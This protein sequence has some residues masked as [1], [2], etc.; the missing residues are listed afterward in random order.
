MMM[1]TSKR[2]VLLGPPGTGKTTA[3][4]GI[5]ADLLASGYRSHEIAFVS[6]SRAAVAEAKDRVVAKTGIPAEEWPWMRTLHSA[7]SRS[8]GLSKDRFLTSSDMRD[9]AAR[10]AIGLDIG[11]RDESS[12]DAY[13]DADADPAKDS[14]LR[15]ALD[16]CR[17]TMAHPRDGI[18]R[19]RDPRREAE[20]YRVF[21]G[22]YEA[23]RSETAK[24]DHTDILEQALADRLVIP[25]RVL[26]VDEAQ[27]LSPLQQATLR[28]SIDKAERVWVAG[29]DDQA[30]YDFQGASPAWL[31][32]LTRSPSWTTRILDRSWRCP[33]EVR[34][35]AQSIAERLTERADKAYRARDGSGRY[36]TDVTREDA[37]A[38]V[39]T[40]TR[41]AFA[42]ARTRIGCSRFSSSLRAA[43]A[44]YIAERGGRSPLD[45]RGLRGVI[46]AL[47]AIYTGTPT[48]A[49]AIA[50]ALSS[51]VCPGERGKARVGVVGRGGKGRIEEWGRRNGDALVTLDRAEADDMGLDRA[52]TL[53]PWDLLAAVQ[54][55]PV[56]AGD[57]R[58]DLQWLRQLWDRNGRAW[59]EHC[60]IVTTWHG[61]KGREADI[62]VIDPALP[63]PAARALSRGGTEADT[64]HRC[65]YV[66]LT[67]ARREAVV[68]REDFEARGNYEF[69]SPAA[70]AERYPAPAPAWSLYASRRHE[71]DAT[72]DVL[73]ADIATP[74]GVT[75]LPAYA[76]AWAWHGWR[77]LFD[78][79]PLAGRD[80]AS[81]RRAVPTLPPLVASRLVE[82]MG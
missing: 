69:P 57:A 79:T 17:A 39:S 27:D 29:D 63:Y 4:M 15:S 40:G 60:C 19:L 65:A 76:L 33:E 34:A 52:Y 74:H 7:W 11:G 53:D 46:D 3:L 20:R 8:L 42:L 77:D 54:A 51:P 72:I 37:M 1:D 28:L 2:I 48:A 30:I 13:L 41:S 55:W 9:F 75:G 59:P 82:V 36:L 43:G 23:F 70:V 47:H 58:T 73:L 38:M 26:I 56:A 35:P 14:H 71:A 5:I 32:G 64:E 62:V 10:S 80:A 61:S 67:R 25:C 21:V 12:E 18:A 66:A 50:S 78:D 31:I 22:E 16:W 6:Y 68:L 24:L 81:A 45:P 44:P 49:S